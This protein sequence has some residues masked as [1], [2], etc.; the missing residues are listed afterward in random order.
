VHPIQVRDGDDL[1]AIY[2]R[3]KNSEDGSQVDVSAATT[4]VLAKFRR[5]GDD[6][7]TPTNLTVTKL[8]G[9]H[10]GLVKLTW[11][12]TALDVDQGRYEIEISVSFDGAVQTV[13]RYYWEGAA[14]LD[15]KTLPVRVHND[16]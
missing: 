9:G 1:P 7:A 14:L 15:S 3:L 6:S 4:T 5:K 10:T 16:F 13:W 8:F 2:A 11:P 12:A